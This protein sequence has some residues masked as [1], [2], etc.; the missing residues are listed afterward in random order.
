MHQ[1]GIERRELQMTRPDSVNGPSGS[2]TQQWGWPAPYAGQQ[3]PGQQFPG[4]AQ[5][6]QQTHQP[7]QQSYQQPYQQAYQSYSQQQ[8]YSNSWGQPSRPFPSAPMAPA[9]SRSRPKPSVGKLVALALAGFLMVGLLGGA[10]L[11]L[12]GTGATTGV[13]PAAGSAATPVVTM[14][15]PPVIDGHP[16]I[17]NEYSRLRSAAGVSV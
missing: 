9:A 11:Y 17:D 5:A 16:Q 12:T 4:Q 13:T 7:Y 1:L 6:P 3:F 15:L 14:S 10:V 8:A 2:P